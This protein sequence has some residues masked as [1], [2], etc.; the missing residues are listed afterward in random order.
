MSAHH[1]EEHH[2]GGHH[3]TFRQYVFI[4]IILFVITLVEFLIIV[5]E[6]LQGSSLVVAPLFILS[7]L[8]FAIVIGWYMHLRFDPRMFTTV[9]LAGL[10]LALLVV[11][12]VLGL[13]GSFQP[14]PRDYAQ[15]HAVPYDP[16]AS[17][18]PEP[19]STAST[20]LPPASEAPAEPSAS[21]EPAAPAAASVGDG[22]AIFL[23]NGQ[24]YTCH[25]I[26]GV[27]EIGVLGPALTGI[28]ADAATRQ[29]GM[30]AEDYLRESILEPD[31]FIQEGCMTGAGTACSP[32]VMAPLV[33]AA[34]LSD[35]DVE[36]LVQYL[37]TQ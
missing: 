19:A 10:F 22:E 33:T 20:A 37:L 3:P 29:P 1:S 21:A 6:S 7:I 28:G 12:A 34:N 32:G 31:A 16:D 4:A 5:P 2:E 13:F 24:C 11:S 14:T 30:S 9:F 26:A 18:A 25:T 17:H 36:A 35:T 15:A 8:K 27:S 23:S